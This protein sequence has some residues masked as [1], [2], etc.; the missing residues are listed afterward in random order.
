MK[1]ELHFIDAVHEQLSLEHRQWTQ[2]GAQINT[3]FAQLSTAEKN[4]S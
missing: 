4:N 3:A 2:D 1:D